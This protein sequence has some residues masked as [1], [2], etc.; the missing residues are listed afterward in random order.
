[1][2]TR[3]FL[4]AKRRE[5]AA[6]LAAVQLQEQAAELQDG[7]GYPERA[8]QARGKA[9]QARVWYRLAGEE[10]TEYQARISVAKDKAGRP[11]RQSA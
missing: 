8:A 5:L 10:L 11:P 4:K 9:E 1:M 6:H 2:L 7:M 3:R